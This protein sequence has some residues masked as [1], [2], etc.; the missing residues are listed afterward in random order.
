MGITYKNNRRMAVL[1]YD[2]TDNK[3]RARIHRVLKDWKLDG[4]KSVAECLLSPTEAEELCA[5]LLEHLDSGTDRLALV[6]RSGQA[7]ARVFGKNSRG[8]Q[9]GPIV[10]H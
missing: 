9:T 4:Q 3:A 7:E 5:Q 2:I 8:R 1:A 6:W 10:F